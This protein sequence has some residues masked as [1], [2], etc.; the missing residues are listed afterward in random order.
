MLVGCRMIVRSFCF[1]YSVRLIF[2]LNF[3]FTHGPSDGIINLLKLPAFRK[4]I[5]SVFRVD[6]HHNRRY[7]TSADNCVFHT[8][9]ICCTS[10]RIARPGHRNYV[11]AYCCHTDTTACFSSSMA[12]T[13]FG[14]D[15]PA[16]THEFHTLAL[17][18]T[19]KEI[20]VYINFTTKPQSHIPWTHIS[21]T[22]VRNASISD[23]MCRIDKMSLQLV[24]MVDTGRDGTAKHIYAHNPV[25]THF[26]TNHRTSEVSTMDGFVD[27]ILLYRNRCS[28]L[29]SAK[30][31]DVF[32]Q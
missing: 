18:C 6:N 20:S 17:T 1:N 24:D 25:S 4:D 7:D 26:H 8:D 5:L 32:S 11:L 30:G 15:K 10:Y 16:R 2:N 14:H 21:K 22:F 19:G 12:D 31:Y 13:C 3:P 28:A 9:I 27:S 23:W 29:V